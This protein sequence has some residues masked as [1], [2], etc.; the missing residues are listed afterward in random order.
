[1]ELES[2]KPLL[3]EFKR[4]DQKFLHR[5]VYQILSQNFT[6]LANYSSMRFITPMFV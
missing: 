1:M 6:E 3:F 5:Q 2:F 4:N